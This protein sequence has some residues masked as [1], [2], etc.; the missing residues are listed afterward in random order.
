MAKYQ[1]E[2]YICYEHHANLHL[3]PPKVYTFTDVLTQ[4]IPKNSSYVYNSFKKIFL[5]WCFLLFFP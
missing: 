3:F 4:G 5:H 2:L 1:N